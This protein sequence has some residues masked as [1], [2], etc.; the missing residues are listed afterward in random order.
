[1]ATKVQAP[2]AAPAASV[3]ITT[4]Q[5]ERMQAAFDAEPSNRLM[6]NA[7][8]QF[9]VNEVALDR[10]LVTGAVHSYSHVLDTWTATEQKRSGRCWIFAALNL[11]RAETVKKLKLDSFEFSQGYLMFWDKVERSNFFL[12]TMIELADRPVDDRTVAWILER[13]LADAGQWDMLVPLVRKYGVVPKEVFPETESSGNT[14]KMNAALS[15]HLRQAAARI[16]KLC[17]TG[18]DAEAMRKV[19]RR[20]LDTVY[21]IL[22]IHLGA[23]PTAFLWQWRDR[24]GTFHRE[25]RM[26]PVEFAREYV[27]TPYEEFVCLVHDPRETSPMGRTFTIAHLGSVVGESDVRYL[28]VDIGLMKRIVMEQVVAGNTVWFGCDTGKQAHGK[29]GIWDADLYDYE[30]VYDVPFS[31]TK[32]ER[33]DYHQSRMTHAML[34]TGVDVV[35]GRPRRWRVENSAGE[36]PGDK[37]FWLM[38]DSWFD[39]YV[40]EIAVH[41]DCVPADLRSAL[42]DDPI[43]L[44]PWDPMGAL[45]G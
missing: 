9:D 25:G 15:Y 21:R 42:G 19:K 7:V 22:C 17:Q 39:E 23:P 1:M 16:R 28:N 10:S 29:L 34:F 33:L 27:T 24:G 11:F 3:G 12:E 30:G 44:P 13:P 37:G 45:A 26:T 18:D 41:R 2:Y 43:V 36:S 38:N 40:S 8:T 5:L 35:D 6:L 32:A 20:T 4:E 14:A 31:M